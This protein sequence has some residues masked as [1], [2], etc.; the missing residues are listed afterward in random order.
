MALLSGGPEFKSHPGR[1]LDLFT[2]VSSSI[3][4]AMLVNNQQVHLLPVGILYHVT[5]NFNLFASLTLE[6]PMM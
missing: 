4:S 2:V 1:S 3:S 5:F 6:N